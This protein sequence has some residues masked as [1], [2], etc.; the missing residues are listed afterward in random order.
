MKDDLKNVVKLI[1]IISRFCVSGNRK[2]DCTFEIGTTFIL[3]VVL[4]K[5]GDIQA[6]YLIIFNVI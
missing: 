6:K 3:L 4:W 1:Y 5:E 2:T